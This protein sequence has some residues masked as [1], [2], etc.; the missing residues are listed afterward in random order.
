MHLAPRVRDVV[1]QRALRHDGVRGRAVEL[2]ELDDVLSEPLVG[3]LVHLVEHEV[4]QVEAREQRGRQVDVVDDGSLRVVL[5]VD[6]VGG[7]EDGRARVERA[8][9]ARLCDRDR[10]LL[11]RLV[12][13]GA[14]A[15]RHLVELVDAADAVVR[16]HERP[17]LEHKLLGLRV[18]CHVR[19]QADRR[20][21]LARSV[22]A[23][24]RDLVHV[25]QQ[26]RLSG[27]RVSDEQNVD[28]AALARRAAR[29][30]LVDHL[31]RGTEELQ[32]DALL[33]VVQ[34]PHRRRERLRQV[35]VEGRRLGQRLE[36]RHARVRHRV[37]LVALV[38]LLARLAGP[39][40]AGGGRDSWLRLLLQPLPLV[41]LAHVHD[42]D[43]RLV[44][45][46]HRAVARV[47][48]DRRGAVHAGDLHSV[49]R[50]ADVHQPSPRAHR[51]RLRRLALRHVLWRLLQPDDL[52][53]DVEGAVV[54]HA[55][56]ALGL[57]RLVVADVGLDDAVMLDLHVLRGAADAALEHG[58]G[59]VGDDLRR[60]RHHPLDGDEPVDVGRVEVAQPVLLDQVE[61]AG[62]DLDGVGVGPALVLDGLEHV[63]HQRDR[64]LRE[65]DQ[66]AVQVGVERVH[67]PA[68]DVDKLLERGEGLLEQLHVVRVLLEVLRLVAEL[69]EEGL[70]RAAE[71]LRV[72]GGAPDLGRRPVAAGA[73][74]VRS[75]VGWCAA[76]GDAPGRRTARLLRPRRSPPSASAPTRLTRAPRASRAAPRA[77]IGRGCRKTRIWPR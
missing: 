33:D 29:R 16:Q 73:G 26:L 47:R 9:D 44:D 32:Q 7:G 54:H 15:V 23:A 35:L 65:G 38:V 34:L 68:V 50:L 43:V 58:E 37:Q 52:L 11:H 63:V 57:A 46:A 77:S 69:G 27:A 62:L 48:A 59:Q 12:Q 61:G 6:R 53:V 17:R 51:D 70:G 30:L 24:R 18:L 19:R 71:L 60:P 42:V 64:L 1:H 31:V 36:L 41:D 13:D 2:V 10:L 8:D 14:R 49:A 39:R 5:G 40:L 55:H 4:N 22:D 3:R 56:R 20:R 45:G 25:L 28:V 75:R 67:V 76:A 66:L 74:A 72:D 21:A